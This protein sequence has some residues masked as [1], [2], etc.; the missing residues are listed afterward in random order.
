[1]FVDEAVVTCIAG[2]GGKGCHSL[3]RS[4]PRHYRPTGGDGGE[5]GSIIFEAQPNIQT[6]L[7]FQMNRHF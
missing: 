2:K 5:G 6:L 3:D 4:R 1:M 7:D